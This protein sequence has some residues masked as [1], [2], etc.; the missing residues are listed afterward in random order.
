[1][2]DESSKPTEETTLIVPEV[3]KP[4][5]NP[6]ETATKS[7]DNT[8]AGLEK[9]EKFAKLVAENLRYGSWTKRFVTIGT[10]AF[11]ALNPVTVG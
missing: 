8:A 10:V 9:A 5:E 2:S 1:M 7:I 3:P 6:I 11:V 4:Q